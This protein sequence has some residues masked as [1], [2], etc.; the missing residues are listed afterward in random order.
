[1]EKL[2][3]IMLMGYGIFM[4]HGDRGYWIKLEKPVAVD[5]VESYNT[6]ELPF[7]EDALEVAF[8]T[9]S[10]WPFKAKN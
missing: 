2:K 9:A 6:P 5:Q 8:Q 7:F 1:M 4:N 10:H 3:Q